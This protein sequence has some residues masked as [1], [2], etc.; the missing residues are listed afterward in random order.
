MDDQIKKM[1]DNNIFDLQAL[2]KA[3]DD[4]LWHQYLGDKA[5]ID[6]WR[7][8]TKGIHLSFGFTHLSLKR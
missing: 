4:V 3:V 6:K 1:R 5:K 2:G 7:T 8:K